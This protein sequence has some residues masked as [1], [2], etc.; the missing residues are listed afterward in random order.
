MAD[1]PVES[2]SR[3][4]NSNR[5]D[6]PIVVI[7]AAAVAMCALFVASNRG[8][9]ADDAPETHLV[10]SQRRQYAGAPPVIRH[11]PISGKCVTCHTAE[12]THKP[13]LGFA[14]AN[15]HTKTPGMSAESR[16][17]QCHAFRRTDERFVGTDFVRESFTRATGSRA[18]ASAPPRIPHTLAMRTDCNAC[19][20]GPSARPEIRCTHPE[21]TRCV[22]CHVPQV[23]PSSPFGDSSEHKSPE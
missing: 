9:T 18:H 2:K 21:R 7:V 23:T 19:H 22:Q 10:R 13:P 17:R 1:N 12:G 15:P 11:A 4:P 6:V 5:S 16:C 14:P 3:K 8:R 20:T